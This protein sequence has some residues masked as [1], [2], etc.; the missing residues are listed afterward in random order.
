MGYRHTHTCS[1]HRSQRPPRTRRGVPSGEPAR[2]RHPH[3]YPDPVPI[4][5]RPDLFVGVVTV[6]VGCVVAW[7]FFTPPSGCHTR[8]PDRCSVRFDSLLFTF[9]PPSYAVG[10]VSC[11]RTRRSGGLPTFPCVL[12][13]PVRVGYALSGCPRPASAL[14]VWAVLGCGAGAA[15]WW[16]RLRSF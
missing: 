8:I 15:W 4:Y 14:L 2:Q 16:S 13:R 3:M 6:T 1:L 12:A 10:V 5:T 7:W 9:A 11:C